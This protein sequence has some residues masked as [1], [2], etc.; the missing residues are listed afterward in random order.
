MSY[1]HAFSFFST[2]FEFH[3]ARRPED[4]NDFR[5][6]LNILKSNNCVILLM[7]LEGFNELP[8]PPCSKIGWNIS[9][10]LGCKKN[11]LLR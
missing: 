6:D 5:Q 1:V 3:Y 2:L 8:Y 4:H 10:I 7:A 9:T 11:G